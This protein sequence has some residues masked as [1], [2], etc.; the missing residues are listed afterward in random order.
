MDHYFDIT[1]NADKELPENRLLGMAYTKLH[2]RLFDMNSRDVGVSFPA[3]QT[4]LGR[5][6]RL[7]SNKDRLAPLHAADWLGGLVGYCAVSEISAI[8]EKVEHRRVC[9]RQAN[10]SF[11]KLRRLKK[12]GRVATKQQERSYKAAMFAESLAIPYV[13]LVSASNGELHRR[14]IE[15]SEPTQKPARGD[16]DSF[17]L[18][19]SAT[20]PWF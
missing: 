12:R 13:E 6:I 16:F 15:I 3:A 8:P 10:K 19:K 5:V 14:F 17:G 7:H 18:S 1:L 20:V 9:R 11:A 2:K 4:T